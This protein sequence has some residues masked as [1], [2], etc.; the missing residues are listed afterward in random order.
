MAAGKQDSRQKMINMMYLVFIAMLALNISKEV[1]GTLGIL[2]EDIETSIDS[3]Y[4]KSQSLYTSFNQNK[5]NPSYSYATAYSSSIKE[6]ADAYFD[7]I[8]NIKE[9]LLSKDPNRYKKKVEALADSITDYQTMDKSQYLDEYFFK[10]DVLTENGIDYVQRFSD[11]SSLYKSLVDS[12]L[13]DESNEK[14]KRTPHDFTQVIDLLDRSFTYNEKVINSEGTEQNYLNYNFEGFPLIASFSKFTKLQSD[15]RE[16]ELQMVEALIDKIKSDGSAVNINTSKTLL[17]AQPSYYVGQS[18][19]DAKIIVGR[20]DGNFVPDSVA[21]QIGNQ[22]LVKGRDFTIGG[23]AVNIKRVFRLAGEKKITGNLYFREANGSLSPIPVEQSLIINNKTDFFVELPKMNILYRGLP[24]EV[25]IT[26]PEIQTNNLR[27]SSK[28]AKTKP[29]GNSTWKVYPNSLKDLEIVISDN[30]NSKVRKTKS[31]RVKNLPEMESAILYNGKFF[32]GSD[33]I[34]KRG[35]VRGTVTG[36]K[37]D[38]FD[39]D[40]TIKV[41]SFDFQI[42]SAPTRSVKGDKLRS[43]SAIIET[44]NPGQVAFFSNIVSTAFSEG[45]GEPI[46]NVKVRDFSIKLK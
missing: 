34:S 3:K 22:K 21:L 11:F 40:L 15:I 37:P 28:G 29:I 33:G 20:I 44:Q 38:D 41:E 24:N 8:D 5:D 27:V 26:D 31:F 17:D 16:L 32:L 23:G 42:G 2:N 9:Y 39:Y 45:D 7:Y 19:S 6:N 14:T 25:R 35:L 30:S 18:T 43:L 12:I 36:S 1:L 46:P 13:V 4:Q 10:G